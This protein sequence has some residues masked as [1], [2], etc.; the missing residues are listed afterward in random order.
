MEEHIQA[1]CLPK[2]NPDQSNLHATFHW[3]SN[4]WQKQKCEKTIFFSCCLDPN[5]QDP[6]HPAPDTK[7]AKLAHN[8]WYPIHPTF[9]KNMARVHPTGQQMAVEEFL[10]FWWILGVWGYSDIRRGYEVFVCVD[11]DIAD[12][13]FVSHFKDSGRLEGCELMILTITQEALRRWPRKSGSLILA[14][15][16][17][18]TWQLGQKGWTV[19][20]QSW[21]LS[22]RKG[23]LPCGNCLVM[24]P[25]DRV[26]PCEEGI[27]VKVNF[28]CCHWTWT[29]LGGNSIL[30]NLPHC[31]DFCWVS[32]WLVRFWI[33]PFSFGKSVWVETTTLE[34]NGS[35]FREIHVNYLFF[36]VQGGGFLMV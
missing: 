21:F 19:A 27:E 20:V 25:Q 11:K 17:I 28:I 16:F 14:E 24:V 5:F 6:A 30:Q 36:L 12:A 15:D 8:N 1:S 9:K 7:V 10:G 33:P 13:N 32:L 26:K 29:V 2:D 35:E 18:S 22:L 23:C 4:A 31:M 34:K 3:F